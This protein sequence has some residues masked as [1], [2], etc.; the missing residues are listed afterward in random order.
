M[1]YLYHCFISFF[2]YW[3]FWRGAVLGLR[4]CAGVSLVAGSRGSALWPRTGF[5][6]Q[7]L[8]LLWTRGSRHGASSSCGIWAQESQLEGPRA[9]AQ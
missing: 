7:W 5:S 8:F 1:Y 4:S 9:W 2:T 6:L 3:V